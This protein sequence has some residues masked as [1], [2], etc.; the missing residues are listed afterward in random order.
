MCV[1]AQL[2][3]VVA[4]GDAHDEGDLVL[5]SKL[6]GPVFEI[7]LQVVHVGEGDATDNTGGVFKVEE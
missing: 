7:V 3:L 2:L 1:F 6:L 4:V 5:G